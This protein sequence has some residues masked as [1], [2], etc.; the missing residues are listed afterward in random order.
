PLV[1]AERYGQPL[2]RWQLLQQRVDAVRFVA[3]HRTR[4][5]ILILRAGRVLDD[6][7]CDLAPSALPS[8]RRARGVRRDAQQPRA[9]RAVAPELVKGTQRVY[10]RILCRILGEV[11]V[12]EYAVRDVVHVGE[13]APHEVLLRLA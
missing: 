7:Q 9:E 1:N 3:C 6:R 10:E 13:M 12:A 8:P 4:G 2:L 11:A 5:R